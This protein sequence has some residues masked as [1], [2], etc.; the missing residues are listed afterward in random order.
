MQIYTFSYKNVKTLRRVNRI[1]L[2]LVLEVDRYP[3]NAIIKLLLPRQLSSKKIIQ[4]WWK[5]QKLQDQ[6]INIQH[7]VRHSLLKLKF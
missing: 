4:N 2:F 3:E 1:E 5:C 6:G 7:L